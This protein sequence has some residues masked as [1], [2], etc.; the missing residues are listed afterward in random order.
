VAIEER[1]VMENHP[2]LEEAEAQ[3]QERFRRERQTQR[4]SLSGKLVRIVGVWLVY[5]GCVG[6]HYLRYM[7]S[8]PMSDTGVA[9]GM[10]GVVLTGFLL[11][12]VITVCVILM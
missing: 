5:F 2:E 7:Y 8:D 12:L 4:L 11:S 6:F 10:L 1:K 3:L 9:L